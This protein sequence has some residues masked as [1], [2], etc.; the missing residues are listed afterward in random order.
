MNSEIVPNNAKKIWLIVLSLGL[1]ASLGYTQ[2]LRY[3]L[4]N[5]GTETKSVKAK[6]D[7]LTQMLAD[8]KKKLSD[9]EDQITALKNENHLQKTALDAF[10]VQASIWE[11]ARKK[12]KIIK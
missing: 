7:A 12:L 6:N 1:V 5:T 3:E 10:Q 8:D 2:Y 11:D 9:L 4:M